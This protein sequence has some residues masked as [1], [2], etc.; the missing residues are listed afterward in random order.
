L[1]LHRLGPGRELPRGS[2]DLW[3]GGGEPGPARRGAEG[4]ALLGLALTLSLAS[5]DALAVESP[6]CH[7][8]R[9]RSFDAARPAAA[10]EYILAT[11]RNSLLSAAFAVSKR[12]IVQAEMSG[13]SPDDLWIAYWAATR[14]G[15]DPGVLLAQ[16]RAGGSW[17]FALA[18][19]EAGR[20]GPAFA[21]ALTRGAPD[22]GLASVAVDDIVVSRLGAKTASVA[23][24]RKAGATSPETIVASVAAPRA[25]RPAES[26]LQAVR[27]GSS[28]WGSLLRDLGIAPSDLDGVVR[29]ALR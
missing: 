12:E 7:C 11:T 14:T 28:T 18:D 5:P 4:R 22:V 13:T 27:Q 15:R 1:G 24:L 26:L 10:D 21:E 3:A 2:G 8:F 17:R 29:R 23:A 20:L 6:S 9:D 19:V 25:G 16:R